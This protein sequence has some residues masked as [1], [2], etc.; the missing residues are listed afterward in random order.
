M[1]AVGLIDRT[2]KKGTPWQQVYKE[3]IDGIIIDGDR[4]KNYYKSLLKK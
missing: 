4:I 2:H 3:G 1:S